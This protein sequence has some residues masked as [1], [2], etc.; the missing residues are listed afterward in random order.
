M[1][2]PPKWTDAVS[3]RSGARWSDLVVAG[4]AAVPVITILLGREPPR[5]A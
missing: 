3:T 1:A 5:Q 2:V 4:P